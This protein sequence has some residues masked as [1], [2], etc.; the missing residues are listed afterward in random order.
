MMRR[1]CRG[2]PLGRPS[3]QSRLRLAGRGE[4][5]TA[6]R[7]VTSRRAGPNRRAIEKAL[8]ADLKYCSLPSAR[9]LRQATRRIPEAP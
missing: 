5:D 7:F 3:A 2:R 9:G 6:A 8:A 4:A 1:I